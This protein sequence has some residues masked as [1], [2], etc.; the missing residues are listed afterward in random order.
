MD[1]KSLNRQSYLNDQQKIAYRRIFA[2][3]EQA[4]IEGNP[5]LIEPKTIHLAMGGW[6]KGDE[7]H[8][9]QALF[10]KV[11]TAIEAGDRKLDLRGTVG[12]FRMGGRNRRLVRDMA[13]HIIRLIA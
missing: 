3:G 9:M 10:N 11:R 6:F 7:V 8:D 5:A 2:A 1:F 4:A 12:A 13:D